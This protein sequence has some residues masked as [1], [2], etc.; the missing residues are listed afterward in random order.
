M[1]ASHKYSDR[2]SEKNEGRLGKMA[3]A[4]LVCVNNRLVLTE[5][6]KFGQ[7]EGISDS[8]IPP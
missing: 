5:G 7:S 6:V 4:F 3:I 8:G 2:K 1:D